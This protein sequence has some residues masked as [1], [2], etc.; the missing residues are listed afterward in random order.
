[1]TPL[2]V[3]TAYHEAWTSK[4]LDRAMSYIADD[5]VCDAPAGRIEGAAAYQAFMAPFVACCSAPS[6]WPP[7][8][9]TNTPWS[10][11]TPVRLWWRVDP[12]LSM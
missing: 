12:G 8:G 9:T 1:M 7:S 2:Q 11:T 4:D 5:I 3:A 6:C 10:S